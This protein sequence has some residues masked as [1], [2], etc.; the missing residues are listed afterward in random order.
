MATINSS[1]YTI[2]S[3]STSATLTNSYADNVGTA[4]WIGSTFEHSL[5]VNYAMGATETS[6][7]LQ[8]IVEYSDADNTLPRKTVPAATDWFQLSAEAVTAG[9]STVSQK[10]FELAAVSAA[11]TADRWVIPYSMLGGKHNWIRVKVQES[12]V[13][14]NYGVARVKVVKNEVDSIN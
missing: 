10:S 4:I 12:G 3:P 2:G 1:Q 14:S 13:A 8:L 7:K 11:L 9:V 5:E 6:N